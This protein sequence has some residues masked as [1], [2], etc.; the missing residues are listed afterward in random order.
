MIELQKIDA[1]CNDCKFMQR[2]QDLMK[3]WDQKALTMA[4][5][6]LQSQPPTVTDEEI[7]NK[8]IE[9][10]KNYVKSL[11]TPDNEVYKNNEFLIMSCFAKACE[12]IN[13]GFKS[14]QQTN[15]E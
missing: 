7:E 5:E 13:I 11:N 2:R 12:I 10:I 6:V 8:I 1:N 9:D 3:E 4:I 15:P 14:K